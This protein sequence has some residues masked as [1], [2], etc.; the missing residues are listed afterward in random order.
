MTW[1]FTSAYQKQGLVAFFPARVLLLRLRFDFI[2][3]QPISAGMID[4]TRITARITRIKN[5]MLKNESNQRILVVT[6][7]LRSAIVKQ[8]PRNP[9][10]RHL[11]GA[12]ADEMRRGRRTE[13]FRLGCVVAAWRFLRLQAFRS[14]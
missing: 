13:A 3:R 4:I 9:I 5:T 14:W 6:M 7:I 8:P 12:L 1:R 10:E 2:V 11:C